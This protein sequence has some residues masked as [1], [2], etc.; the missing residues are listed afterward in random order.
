MLT[1]IVRHV[2]RTVRPTNFKLGMRIEDD[3]PHQHGRHYLQGQRS[4]SQDHVISLSR[5]GPML[6]LS[7]QSGGGIPCRL[8]PAVTLLVFSVFMSSKYN[9]TCKNL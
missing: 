9:R 5:L 3:D 2:F 4:R 7:L 1:H 6:Y 8:N